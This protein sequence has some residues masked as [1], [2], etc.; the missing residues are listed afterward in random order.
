LHSAGAADSSGVHLSSFVLDT[1]NSWD[2]STV[3]TWTPPPDAPPMPDGTP[4]QPT[5]T[6]QGSSSW[7]TSHAEGTGDPVTRTTTSFSDQANPQL[8]T[9]T[10]TVSPVRPTLPTSLEAAF[11]QF[12]ATAG[13]VATRAASAFHSGGTSERIPGEWPTNPRLA[14][15]AD[16]TKVLGGAQEPNL[17]ARLL[18]AAQGQFMPMSHNFNLWRTLDEATS[19][20]SHE[21][22]EERAYREAWEKNPPKPPS[23]PDTQMAPAVAELAQRMHQA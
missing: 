15:Y 23:A 20:Q 21:T 16:G 22:P 2:N 10:D 13:N 17:A 3:T 6:T 11:N 8:W 18:A 19:G 4:Q 7:S 5:S 12:V 14:P 9:T 1:S